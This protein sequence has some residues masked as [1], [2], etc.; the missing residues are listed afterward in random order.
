MYSPKPICTCIQCLLCQFW[1]LSTPLYLY[2]CRITC[3]YTQAVLSLASQTLQPHIVSKSLG[4]QLEE[5][6]NQITSS[7]LSMC[8]ALQA[9][10]SAAAVAFT[11][12][13]PLLQSALPASVNPQT[14]PKQTG[15]HII[16]HKTSTCGRFLRITK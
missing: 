12:E 9:A 2:C 16:T 8:A 4:A 10:F 14:L 11:P 3:K 5:Q 1:S 7:Y 13:T 6:N 15:T